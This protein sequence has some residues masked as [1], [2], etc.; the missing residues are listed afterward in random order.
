MS[1]VLRAASALAVTAALAAASCDKVP[2]L[3]PTNSTISLIASVTVLP[4]N[5]TADI[6]AAVI[7]SAGTPV[8][9]GT[10][11]T[12]TSSLGTIEPRD[13]RTSNG[14]VTVRFIAGAQSGAAKI[15]AFSG[16]AKAEELEILV[17]GAAAGALSVRANPAI[18]PTTGGTADIIA[19]VV[20]TGG[21]PLR[22]VPVTFSTTFGQLSQG[23]AISDTAGEARTQLTTNVN[24]TVT[25][26]VGGGAT[27]PTAT[28]TVEARSAP[29]VT[30]SAGTTQHRRGGTAHRLHPRAAG[31][32]HQQRHPRGDPQLRR[33]H[34]PQSRLAAGQDHRRAHL[35]PR[36]HLHA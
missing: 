14:Q 16:G 34:G 3:A 24:A 25:A 10:V 21:N 5:G 35:L 17:G 28:V 4:T 32:G 1:P 20:D 26:R 7:E 8:Q 22:G 33:R 31:R 18:V 9:N 15:G 27:A 11:V 2:L 12:F 6:T 30:I 29:A 36:R 13:A 19:T 23:T